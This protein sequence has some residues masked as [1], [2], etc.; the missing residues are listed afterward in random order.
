MSDDDK[1]ATQVA[2]VKEEC[3]DADVGEITEEFRRYENEFLIPPND[4][5]RSVIRK[6]QAASGQEMT[7]IS[8]TQTRIEKKVDRFSDLGSDDKN[9]TIEV[10]VVT[11]VPRVQMVR[12]EEKQIAFGWIED[13]PW[14]S[15][16]K[17]ERWDF[18][19]WGAHS[20]NLAPNSVVRLEG[21]SV[22]EW[23]DKRSININRGSRVTV[24]REG[25]PA[26]PTISDEP[27]TIEKASEN[28]GYVNLLARIISLKP[29]IIVKKDGSGSLDIFRGTFADSSGKISF[30][31][32]VPINHEV[33]D[34]VKV[35]GAMIRKFRET[36]EVNIND[37][38]KIEK[39]HDNNF[40]SI[41][42]LSKA[43]TSKIGD[44]RN[45][46]K[47]II[48][49]VQVESW[50]SRSFTN[51]EGEEKIVRS[52]DVMD[53]TGRCRLTAWCDMNPKPGD[54][55]H[56]T[57]ARVQFWQGSPDLVVDNIDQISNLTDAPWEAIDPEQ[58]WVEIELSDLVN[59]GSRRGI[60]TRGTIVAVRPDSGI[61]ERCPECRR[62]LRDSNCL[63]HGAQHGVED[64]R[65]KFV[66]DNGI[67]NASLI[68]AK[69]PSEEFLGMSQEMVKE[70]ISQRGKEDFVSE[71]RGKSLARKVVINGRSLVDE[72][73]AMI[74]A[75]DVNFDSVSNEDTANIVVKEWGVL[76]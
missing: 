17:R 4:A 64:L 61:I 12:G 37:R 40:A 6:F 54:F 32:W 22:N 34:L 48:T 39:Y 13:N 65:L 53:P 69:E 46:M 33:G 20:E 43:T 15:N 21:V 5:L 44:L 52:G 66:I 16:D 14:E 60:K 70:K 76:L 47:D 25:G 36:P 49:T 26:V 2:L 24:L 55:L 59:S 9:V 35:E 29:D 27:V 41:E 23:N 45:G 62:I 75:E 51:S 57:G 67:H 11:Y 28:E 8:P 72:Q 1:Y 71:V 10:A 30:L 7:T 63:D 31:S 38:T 74:L 19:D 56:L 50:Q 18:K 58:H 3:K 68:L 73:G 42:E